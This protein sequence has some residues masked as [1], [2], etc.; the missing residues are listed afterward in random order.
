[1]GADLEIRK[2]RESGGEKVADLRIRHAGRL[3]G[4][5]IPAAW[6]PS[7]IDELP[8]IFAL[9][10]RAEGTTRLRGAAELRVKE[11]DRLAVMARGLETLGVELVEYEDGIDIRG[12][13]IG[14]GRVDGAG[15]H[16]CAM[17]FCVLGQVAAG[18]VTVDGCENINTSYP[19]FVA[20]LA[21]IGGRIVAVEEGG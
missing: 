10:A 19:G 12:G 11:S 5:D 15:D 8:V 2:P 4:I 21:G 14:A 16:R 18:P 1:M 17:S 9:A 20:D 7:L 6:V 3:K 13:A